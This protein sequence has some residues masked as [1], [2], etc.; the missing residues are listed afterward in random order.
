MQTREQ[1]V[2]SGSHVSLPHTVSAYKYRHDATLLLIADVLS[3][4]QQLR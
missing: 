2:T 3:V 4:Y 1:F